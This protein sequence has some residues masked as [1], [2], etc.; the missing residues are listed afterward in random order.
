MEIYDATAGKM[1]S[2]TSEKATKWIK[3]KQC[4]G[5]RSSEMTTT[6]MRKRMGDRPI[7]QQVSPSTAVLMLNDCYN[8]LQLTFTS[9]SLCSEP[10]SCITIQRSSYPRVY[11]FHIWWLLKLV[12]GSQCLNFAV[13]TSCMLDALLAWHSASKASMLWLCCGYVLQ[14]TF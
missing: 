6:P 1:N 12:S 3:M 10:V 9:V 14:E 2:I 7:F 5:I 11:I 8:G 4:V 13:Y